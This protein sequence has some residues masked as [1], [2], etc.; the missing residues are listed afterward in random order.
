VEHWAEDSDVLGVAGSILCASHV[1]SLWTPDGTSFELTDEES[2]LLYEAMW[3]LAPT[4]RGA[5]TAAAKIKQAQALAGWRFSPVDRLDGP[6]AELVRRALAA[7]R[8]E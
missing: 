5:V 8:E 3:G 1:L 7:I 2:R 4:V 6:E